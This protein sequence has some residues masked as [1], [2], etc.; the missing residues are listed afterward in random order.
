MTAW[1]VPTPQ[2]LSFVE[3]GSLVSEQLSSYGVQAP[4]AEDSWKTWVAALF[5]VPE[6]STLNVPSAD[7]FASWQDWA[8]QF[9]GCV[10]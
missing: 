5:Y 3:W 7:G 10:R 1:F 9:I 8:Q 2:G 4:V 6:L